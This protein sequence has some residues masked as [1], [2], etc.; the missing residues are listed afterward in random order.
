MLQKR[1]RMDFVAIDV[2]T[3]NQRHASICQIGI[4]C[5][6]QG[7]LVESWGEFV[8]PEDS[9]L[10]FNTRLHGIGPEDVSAAPTWPELRPKLRSLI[11]D[12]T[13]ASHTYFDRTALKGA[14]LRYGL[15]SIPVPGWVDTCRVARQVWPELANHKLTSLARHFGLSYRAH[16]AVEDARCAGQVLVLAA[17]ASSLDLAEML[18]SPLK[19]Q[20]P[21][22]LGAL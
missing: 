20:I 12:R 3:A 1:I 18:Q 9:F 2:E 8:D 14:D 16:D 21:S 17:H 11:K 7:A 19:R 6:R 4:A 15:P 13:I 22:D 10:P 5:F